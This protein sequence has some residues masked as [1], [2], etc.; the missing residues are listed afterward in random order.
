[1]V[2]KHPKGPSRAGRDLAPP[3]LFTLE[4]E[5]LPR[6]RLPDTELAPDVAYQIIHDEPCSTEMPG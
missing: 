6:H 2:L 3:P 1:M 5:T 4:T